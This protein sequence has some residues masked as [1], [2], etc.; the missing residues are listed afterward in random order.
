MHIVFPILLFTVNCFLGY[1]I[2]SKLVGYFHVHSPG[3]VSVLRSNSSTDS[4]QN[5]YTIYISSFSGNTFS[6]DH[7]Y[8][9]TNIGNKLNQL[10]QLKPEVVSSH[11]VWPNEIHD[12]PDHVFG[13]RM[14][15][16]AGGFLVPFKTKGTISVIDVSSNTIGGLYEL[17]KDHLDHD[18]FYHRI[19]WTDMNGDGLDDAVT[20]R[21]KKSIIGAAHGELLWFENPSQVVRDKFEHPWDHFVIGDHSDTYFDMATLT[22]PDG[23]YKCIV[24]TGFFSNQL[25][26]VVIQEIHSRVI[27]GTHGHVFDVQI[28]DLNKDGNPDLL[29]TTNGISGAAVYAF[30]VPHDFRYQNFF[31]ENTE[32]N[33]PVP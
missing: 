23:S 19:L 15:S 10:D 18:W 25:N 27:V 21:A 1:C 30:E 12:V 28:T 29:V 9:L 11:I 32:T 5:E 6:A 4:S 13:K 14:V 31:V 3:F 20:C 22:T 7:V 17:A 26:L 2:N 8:R 16:I 24:T 33:T